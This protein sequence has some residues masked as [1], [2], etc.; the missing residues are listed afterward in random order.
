MPHFVDVDY[1]V[2]LLLSLFLFKGTPGS[3]Q[4]TLCNGVEVTGTALCE[5][6]GLLA[7][8]PGT[9]QLDR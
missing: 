7:L 2:I 1:D 6:S 9:A 8:Y 3:G 4:L 5:G